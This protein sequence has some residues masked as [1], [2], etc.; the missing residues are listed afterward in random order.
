MGLRKNV[1]IFPAGTEIA[2][3]IV[4]ALKYSKF[5]TLFGGTSAEDHSEFIYK[6]IICGFP[7][8]DEPTFLSFLNNVI[9]EYKIDCIY[10]AH[11]SVSVFLSNNLSEIKAQV[12]ISDSFTTNICRSK[13]ETYHFFEDEDF[14]PMSY[15]NINSVP[16]YPV[17]IKPAV[18]QGSQGAQIIYNQE[19][20]R[21][22]I[23]K[24]HSVVI[25]EFLPGIEYTV[26]CFTDQYG[27]L[28]TAIM[29][30]RIR[31]RAGISV[32]SRVMPYNDRVNYIAEKINAKLHFKGAWF[33]QL[34]CN[35]CGEFKLLEISPRIPG[36]MGLSRNLGINF[37]LLTLLVF[38]GFDINIIENNYN[39]IVDKAFY[40]T[41]KIN[42]DY[43]HIYL[44]YDDTII[45]NGNV[46]NLLIA[47]L[48]QAAG[49]G[50]KIH[51]LTKHSG[52][53]LQDLKKHKIS[54]NLFDSIDVIKPD[55]QKINYIT[56]QSSIFIDD[57]FAERIKVKENK[58]IPVFDVDTIECL[59]D[60]R[61]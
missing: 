17:F 23:K 54:E 30:D 26:D 21:A 40:S 43:E 18:G 3:E 10:P 38:W 2:F 49:K 13:K 37:P 52:N 31:I 9:E 25:C 20:L 46:N 5:V 34:K 24:D 27:K 14:T 7:Y 28:R 6:N 33:F 8:V 60:W 4:N 39:I 41:Y 48:Y 42:Y 59:I 51:L 22:A 32:R 12:I 56:E 35:K 29:R 16:E 47:F 15:D 44:D 55:E 58:K 53:L 11:D 57:S 45:I 61:I 36:T 1:L 50:K 19:E